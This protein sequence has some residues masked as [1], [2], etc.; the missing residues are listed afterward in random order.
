MSF[1]SEECRADNQTVRF[2]VT[3]MSCTGCA[4]TLQ[5]ALE[6]RCGTARVA[7]SFSS[8]LATVEGPNLCV[9]EIADIVRRRGFGAELVRD[10]ERLNQSDIE[11]TDAARELIWRR[12][13]AVGISLWLPLEILHW[14]AVSLHW[15]GVW[16][17]WMM[18]S[19]AAVVLLFAGTEFYRSAWS[20]ARHG[21]TNMDTLIA[22]GATTAFIYSTM[23]LLLQIDQPMYFA[24]SAGLLGIVSLGH[25]F[26]AKASLKAGSA[27]RELLRLQ[28][29]TSEVRQDDGTYRSIPTMQ[30][31]PGDCL[32]IR[33]GSRIPVDGEVIDG[34]SSVDQS[35]VTGESIPIDKEPGDTVVAGAMNLSGQLV[36][37]AAVDGTRTTVCR[38]AELV[39]KAQSGRAPIQ[40]LADQVSSVFI[41]VVLTIA[42]L[43]LAGWWWS[44][45]FPRGVISAVT[46][47]IISCPCALG[48][49]T[50]MAV[51]V[52]TGA[53]SQRGILIRTAEALERAGRATKV[54][55]DKTGTITEGHPELTSVCPESGVSEEEM[56][57]F[58][59]AVEQPSEHPVGKAIVRH[60][61]QRGL[62]IPGVSEFRTVPGHGVTGLV[63]GRRVTVERGISTAVQITVDG[64]SFGTF[65]VR[66]EPRRDAA[67]AIQRLESGNVRV[68]MLTGDRAE[69]A[70]HIARQT[71]ISE[72]NVIAEATPESKAA[73]VR[74]LGTGTIMVGDGLNDAAAL[75]AAETG[76]A[77]ASGTNVAIESAS[78]VIPGDRVSAVVELIEL[79]RATLRT[80]RQNLF[81]AFFYNAIAI[82]VAAFGLLGHHGPLWAALAMGLSDLTVVGNA[83]RLRSRLS[84]A[85]RSSGS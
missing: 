71:G 6:D 52:G 25:W 28:P 20:A 42:A 11:R 39:Q 54:V 48:L 2:R 72:S 51:M 4:A 33:P 77:M 7:V 15:H 75:A 13:A 37:R 32:L 64:R 53:A 76:V 22:L 8:G 85:H 21:G 73:L 18:F 26:E 60:T 58:A 67:S 47:L 79:S 57:K 70:L 5:K 16:M 74:S 38:I 63:N 27:V 81:F 61:L 31:I 56:L 78:V 68:F 17:A 35:I 44:G 10:S 40:R 65:T 82:P 36:L 14:V 19:G 9:S 34:E 49:A 3:G 46:V 66:D 55:F 24:E 43:T 41:P 62:I 59:A 29:E 23:V 83:L 69:T 1:E 45:D 30:V 50:P 84:R 12:R 80:I